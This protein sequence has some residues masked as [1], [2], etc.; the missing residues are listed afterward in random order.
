M[1][2][3]EKAA[4]LTVPITRPITLL[5]TIRNVLRSLNQVVDLVLLWIWYVEI[6]IVLLGR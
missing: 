2:S 1:I 3:L 6:H 5:N 4:T